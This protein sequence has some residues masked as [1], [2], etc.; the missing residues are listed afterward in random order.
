MLTQEN[1]GRRNITSSKRTT[2]VTD[3]GGRRKRQ[4]YEG[5][6]GLMGWRGSKRSMDKDRQERQRKWKNKIEAKRE[7]EEEGLRETLLY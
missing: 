2:N 4:E 5:E 7:R 1:P 6:E 3:E